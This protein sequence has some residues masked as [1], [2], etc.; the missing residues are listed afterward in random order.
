MEM[1]MHSESSSTLNHHEEDT[2]NLKKG[3]SMIITSNQ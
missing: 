2:I 3:I 1:Q